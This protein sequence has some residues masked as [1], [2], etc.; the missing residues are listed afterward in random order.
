MPLSLD[1]FW[2]QMQKQYLRALALHSQGKIQK[3][4]QVARLSKPRLYALFKK[5]EI[6]LRNQ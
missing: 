6:A 4:I 1:E 2:E 3:A 5:N